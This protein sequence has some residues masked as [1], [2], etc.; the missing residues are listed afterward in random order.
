M[1]LGLLAA[2]SLLAASQLGW[3][4]ITRTAWAFDLWSYLP[5][6]AAWLLAA[7]SLSLCAPRVRGALAA[8]FAAAARRFPAGGAGE[9]AACA[10]VAFAFWLL[11]EQVLTGDSGVLVTAANSGNEFVFPEVGAT[12]LLRSALQLARA[13]DLDPVASMRVLACVSGGLATWLLLRVAREL[14]PGAAAAAVVL[15]LFSGGFARIFA[16]RIE[17]YAPLMAAVLA[18]LWTALRALRGAGGLALPAL[19]LGVAIWLHAAAGL[20]GPSL[21][22]LGV[23]RSGRRR[24][25]GAWREAAASVSLAA[26]PLVGFLVVQSLVGGTTAALG[27]WTRVLEILGRGGEAG[28]T[29]W[30]VRGWGGA[31]SIGTDVVWLSR[32]HLKYL[33]N[34]FSLLVPTCLP[35]LAFLLVRRPRTLLAGATGHWLA[36]A[37]LPLCLYATALRPFWGPW[38]WDLFALTALVLTCLCIRALAPLK[39]APGLLAACIGFQ[40]CFVGIPFLWIGT[41]SPRDVGPFGFRSF[42]YDLRQPARPPPERIAPWL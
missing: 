14:V 30:W 27:A 10:L 33:V 23:L 8:G 3:L 40:L 36:I 38:D 6:W 15:L 34:A 35:G 37:A 22:A 32:P 41:G 11:R 19:C 5:E 16:G 26:A 42:D 21:L 13:H 39:L 17:V 20:L 1:S 28:A 9:A 4:P 2:W 25:R 18:Y 12:F 24:G 31:P 7:A 29:R